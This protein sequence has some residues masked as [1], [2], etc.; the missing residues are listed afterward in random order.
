M[1]RTIN[2]VIEN[3]KDEPYNMPIELYQ[4]FLDEETLYLAMYPEDI[5]F[6]DENGD[7]QTYTAAALSRSTIETNT[8]TQVDQCEVQIDNVTREMSA[9]IANTEF[10]DRELAIWKV[11][12]EDLSDPQ[13]YVEIFRGK[14]D[15]P[16]INQ[17]QMS[18]AVVSRLDTLDR[19]LPARTFQ[20]QCP[21]QFGDSDTCG[22]TVPEKTGTIDSI[23]SDHMTMNDSD[24][25]ES[26]GYWEHGEITINNEKRIITES[27]S[28][29]VT[30]EYPF[31][32]DVEAG[33][34]Y[35]MQAGCNK[36]YDGGVNSCSGWGNTD[37][38]GGFLSIP[39]T[40]IREV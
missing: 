2:A 27:G 23:S 18:V 4:I 11:F 30:V 19:K 10:V 6:F 31:S 15:A 25:T 38:Y 1:P 17:Y 14:M 33:D 5:E 16:K 34:N 26:I 9:Y 36:S 8:D 21:W 24:I 37:Y 39:K 40:N 29:Y 32:A 35:E 13:N 12:L 3:L 7:P 22:A 20:V 28:G